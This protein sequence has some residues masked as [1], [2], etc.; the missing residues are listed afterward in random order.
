MF[1]QHFLLLHYHT[2]SHM[3]FAY[4]NW[5]GHRHSVQYTPLEIQKII[6]LIISNKTPLIP[7]L[8][9][10]NNAHKE[11]FFSTHVKNS[12]FISLHLRK[13]LYNNICA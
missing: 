7:H 11:N 4:Q 9:I 5:I 2:S 8:M 3:Q 12:I 1:G 10:P 6:Y 13:I